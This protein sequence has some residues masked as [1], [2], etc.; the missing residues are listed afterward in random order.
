VLL[1]LARCLKREKAAIDVS[2]EEVESS[3][4]NVCEEYGEEPVQGFSFM[5][6]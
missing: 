3:Y 1:A 2:L 4:H 6:W 5:L